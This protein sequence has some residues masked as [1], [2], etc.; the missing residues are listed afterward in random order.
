MKFD[1]SRQGRPYVF[2]GVDTTTNCVPGPNGTGIGSLLWRYVR[3][4]GLMLVGFFLLYSSLLHV[5]GPRA[6]TFHN[7]LHLF[8]PE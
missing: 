2:Y 3:A 6:P 1:Q 4:T 5:S 7:L 8:T